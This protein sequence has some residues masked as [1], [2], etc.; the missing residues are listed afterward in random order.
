[1]QVRERAGHA[2]VGGGR[3]RR[4]EE[5]SGRADSEQIGPGDA[6]RISE[7]GTHLPQE[8]PRGGGH[9]TA[10]YLWFNLASIKCFNQ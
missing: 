2:S 3:H 4:A 1:M 7:G 5:G 9:E 10:N 6:D 8:E